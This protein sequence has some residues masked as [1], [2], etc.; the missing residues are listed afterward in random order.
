[1]ASLPGDHYYP[2]RLAELT[3]LTRHP[4]PILAEKWVAMAPGG[5]HHHAL[6]SGR[7]QLWTDPG[8]PPSL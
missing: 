2:P 5:F 1:M 7:A 4:V 8:G 3:D 6:S